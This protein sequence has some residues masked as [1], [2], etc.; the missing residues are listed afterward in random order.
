MSEPLIV[1]LDV[2]YRAETAVAAGL[3]FR[4][5]TAAHEETQAIAGFREVAAY[6]PGAFY[7][8]ELPC[9]LGVLREGPLADIVIV[10]GYVSLEPG[11]P[12][13]GAHLHDALDRQVPVVG[14]AKTAYRSASDVLEVLRGQSASP[15]FVTAI[16]IDLATAAAE[17]KRMHGEHRVPALLR[18]VDQ[19]A[20]RSAMPDRTGIVLKL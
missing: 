8:R 18:A 17:V 7:R 6:E 3:W 5:W 12:G 19:L 9:L 10:D 2:D 15:L 13:L 14:V 16:G 20:R 11:H 4:G 1:C